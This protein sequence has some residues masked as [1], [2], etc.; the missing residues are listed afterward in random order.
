MNTNTTAQTD[1][2]GLLGEVADKYLQQLVQGE[3][4]DIERYAEQHPEIA[5]LIRKTFPALQIVNDSLA[6]SKR[7]EGINLSSS[8]QLGDFRLLH[9]LGSGGMGFVYEAEQLSMGRHVALKILPMAGAL[10]QKQLLRFR[11]EVRAAAMLDHPHIV[12]VYSI[13]EDRG[14]HFYAMQLI[15]GQ[16]LAEV[17]GDL[18]RVHAG[19]GPLSGGLTGE[20]IR[21]AISLSDARPASASGSAN[22]YAATEDSVKA[23]AIAN[24]EQATAGTVADERA[25]LADDTRPEIKAQI[26][27]AANNSHDHGFFRSAAKLGIQAAEALQHAHDLGVLHRDIKPGNLMLDAEA[28][29][30]ITDFGL[31][32][33]E[34]DAGVTMTGDILGTLRYMSPEQALAKRVIIDQRSDIYSLGVTL[35]ELLTLQPAFSGNDRQSLLQQIAFEEPKLPTRINRAIPRELETIV[36]KAIAKNPRERYATAQEL[37]DDLGRY[38]DDMPIQAKRPSLLQRSTKWTHRNSTFVRT[39]VATVAIAV[40]IGGAL[41]WQQRSETLAALEQAKQNAEQAETNE[42][43]ARKSAADAKESEA[44]AEANLVLANDAAKRESLQR[45]LAQ[46][47]LALAE[48]NAAQAERERLVAQENFRQT[49]TAVDDYFTTVSTNK[50]LDK[51]EL[52]PLRQELLE[53]AVTYYKGFTE[54]HANDSELAAELAA[55]HL[56]LANVYADQGSSGWVDEFASVLDIVE[57]LVN[58]GADVSGWKGLREGV[59]FKNARAQPQVDTKN[60][61]RVFG[62]CNR[63][64]P[65]WER[66]VESHPDVI[67]FA[68]DLAGLHLIQGAFYET[69]GNNPKAKQSFQQVIANWGRF[70]YDELGDGRWVYLATAHSALGTAYL[71]DQ[72]WELSLSSGE[73][74][75][76]MLGDPKKLPQLYLYDYAIFRL[77]LSYTL[78]EQAA[79]EL[80]RPQLAIE[81]NREAVQ[82][83]RRVVEEQRKQF[84]DESRQVENTLARLSAALSRQIKYYAD[85][86]MDEE[87]AEAERELLAVN[88][89]LGEINRKEYEIRIAANPDDAGAQNGLAWALAASPGKTPSEYELAKEHAEKAVELEPFASHIRNTLGIACLRARDFEGAVRELNMSNEMSP[90][91][92]TANNGFSLAMAYQQLGELETARR[93]FEAASA[94]HRKKPTSASI[95]SE[96]AALLG[97]SDQSIESLKKSVPDDLELYSLALTADPEAAWAYVGRGALLE[98][99]GESKQA[100]SDFRRATE[101]YNGLLDAASGDVQYPFLV[102]RGTLYAKMGDYDNAATDFT[103]AAELQPDNFSFPYRGA[104]TQLGAGESEGYRNSCASMLEQ[105]A[106]TED[107]QTANFTAWSCALAADAVDD[108]SLPVGLAERAGGKD[109]SNVFHLNALGAVLYRAG[110]FDEALARL[111]EAESLQVEPNPEANSSA[112]YTWFFFAM[113]HYRLGNVDEAR[114]WYEKAAAWTSEVL[115]PESEE[116]KPKP[117]VPWNRRLTLELLHAETEQLLE[118][119]AAETTPEKGVAQ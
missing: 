50:L 84:G 51:L 71:N 45:E 39:A 103:K 5:S 25:E 101:L 27:T 92:Y 94:W 13:G 37:A 78:M 89:K 43:L 95:K 20:S 109:P 36:M 12:S 108:F 116:G 118:I 90:G 19:E 52:S 97:I 61:L 87:A 21:Q 8:K 17:I 88:R 77:D 47:N 23:S 55:A 82:C 34:A 28:Q 1:H 56:R 46:A 69:V 107:P 104:L 14:V 30:H 80:G 24:N 113:T 91:S 33:I 16:S 2:D 65:V 115:A 114:Q 63:A 79:I 9:E 41:L 68:S 42:V 32:R 96:A 106:E 70:S 105:F 119:A 73:R 85:Q 44:R 40:V 81:K 86:G 62:L 3:K 7:G 57:R 58:Q 74:V 4:P 66:L 38:L 49:R 67:G 53:S 102:S 22:A 75:E 54:T 48:Q 76:Q 10:Q 83:S 59:L 60:A 18:Q 64:I 100:T 31:A 112:A 15:R 29:L 93:W 6:E 110:R 117:S 98:K 72:E 35:Y 26:S 99:R 11:N 111:D